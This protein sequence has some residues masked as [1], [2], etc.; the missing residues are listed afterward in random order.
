MTPTLRGRLK[1]SLLHFTFTLVVAASVAAIVFLLWYPWPY[2]EVSGGAT[3]FLLI[4]GVDV[5]LGPLITLVVFDVTKRKAELWRDMVVVV[6]LQLAGLAYGT[7]TMF[8]ARPVVLALEGERFRVAIAADVVEAELPKAPE[9]LRSLSLTGP[10]LVGT[11]DARGDET[12]DAVMAAMGGA[13]LGQRPSFWRLW[14]EPSRAAA[15]KA[16]KPVAELLA[17]HPAQADDLR[18]AVAKTGK[19]IEQLI[20]IPML[21]KRNDWSVLLD[22]TSGDPAGFAPVDGF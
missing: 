19:P 7:H 22:K 3:L 18:A 10:K 15:R 6:A 16:G 11:R 13:D 2:S 17:K 4:V 20:Y 8:V 5:V 21:A 12:F 14:D 1:A 9:G